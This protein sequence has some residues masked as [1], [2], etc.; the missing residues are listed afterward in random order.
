MPYDAPPDDLGAT[1]PAALAR[2]SH[3]VTIEGKSGGSGKAKGIAIVARRFKIECRLDDLRLN[4]RIDHDQWRAGML[5]RKHWHATHASSCKC[6]SYGD[7]IDSMAFS[8]SAIE[9]RSVALQAIDHAM[10]LLGEL[11]RKVIVSVC[12]EDEPG[13][14]DWRMKALRSGLVT[15]ADAWVRPVGELRG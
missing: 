2:S 12:G 9:Q 6:S 5:F 8:V 4:G 3:M 10:A 13:R 15:L 1:G 14:L 11:E 7:R